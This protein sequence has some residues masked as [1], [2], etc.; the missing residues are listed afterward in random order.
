MAIRCKYLYF[1]IAIHMIS[2][3]SWLVCKCKYPV[4]TIMIKTASLIIIMMVDNEFHLY[5]L[6][7]CGV[8]ILRGQ[9]L[10]L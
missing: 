10:L 7:K 6:S 9:M 2:Q 3:Y 4:V 8:L 1:R 5:R